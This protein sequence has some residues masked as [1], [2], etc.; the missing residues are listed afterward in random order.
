[1]AHINEISIPI[2]FAPL[3][4]SLSFSF[5][6]HKIHSVFICVMAVDVYEYTRETLAAV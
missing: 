3:L 6:T 1:M 4:L 2:L 5:N